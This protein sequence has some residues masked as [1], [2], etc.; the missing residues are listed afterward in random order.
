MANPYTEVTISP[1]DDGSTGSTNQLTWAKHK[2]KLG[3]PLKTGVESTQTN[4]TSAFAKVPFSDVIALSSAHTQIA[5]DRG[6]I[7]DVSS[8]TFT[9]DLLLAATAGAGFTF[10]IVNNGSGVV[11]L[12]GSASEEINGSTTLALATGG[13]GLFTCNGTSWSGI[14]GTSTG[15]STTELDVLDGA[16]LTTAELNVLDDS[17]QAVS[18]YATGVREYVEAVQGGNTT[19][20][21]FTTGA[22]TINTWYD[23][24]PTS[25][26]ADDD[27]TALDDI[28]L[29]ANYVI[30]KIK[31]SIQAS[32]TATWHQVR[33]Y[34]RKNGEATT[35]STYAVIHDAHVYNRSGSNEADGNTTTCYLPVDANNRFELSWDS[36]GSPTSG[37]W[38]IT[39]VGWG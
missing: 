16:T 20:L 36:T 12:D 26:G 10:G 35:Q 30:L 29:G 7:Y 5:T 31:G 25:G 39:L 6:K 24:G 3:D 21:S 33:L 28:P 11:T 8:G 37:D 38:T 19:T 4:I 27:W 15:A 18:G 17:V 14:V 32:T 34:G 13:S 22:R 1:S 23:Y 9:I 2:T